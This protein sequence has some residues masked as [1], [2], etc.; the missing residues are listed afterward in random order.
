MELHVNKFQH[1]PIQLD[2]HIVSP[3]RQALVAKLGMEYLGATLAADGKRCGEL[4]QRI[5][6]ARAVFEA[7]AKICR[8]STHT[9]GWKLRAYSACVESKLLPS[10]QRLFEYVAARAIE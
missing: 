2:S 4:S 3:D 6:A 8:H 5:G 7:L 9:W 10:Q 1:L